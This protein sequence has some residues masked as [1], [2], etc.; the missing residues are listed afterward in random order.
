MCPI[1]DSY[2]VMTTWNLE[3]KVT[4][5]DTKRKKVTN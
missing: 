4:I 1:L 3:Q 2:E 5:I